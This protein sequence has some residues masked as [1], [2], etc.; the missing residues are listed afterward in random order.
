MTANKFKRIV[1]KIRF[2]MKWESKQKTRS[3]ILYFLTPRR[4]VALWKIQN[5]DML[6]ELTR[7]KINEVVLSMA[8]E[9]IM[10][11]FRAFNAAFGDELT[12]FRIPVAL[13]RPRR[14]KSTFLV[15]RNF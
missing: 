8:S 5:K 14:V 9:V 3:T 2:I 10:S 4:C 1:Q 6:M 7:R 13:H 11:I 15:L 12:T